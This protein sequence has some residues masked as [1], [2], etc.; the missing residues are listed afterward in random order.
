MS[1]RIS[2]TIS[3]DPEEASYIAALIDLFD[4]DNIEGCYAVRM[5]PELLYHIAYIL[6]EKG[7]EDIAYLDDIAIGMHWNDLDKERIAALLKIPI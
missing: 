7:L 2:I 4:T 1:N 5:L 3:V 6:H